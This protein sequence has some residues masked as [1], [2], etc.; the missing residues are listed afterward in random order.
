MK[1]GK[2]IAG[3]LSGAAIGA[4]AGML[5]AP[6]KGKDTRKQ[7]ADRSNEYMYDTKSKFN[8]LADNLSH[9]YD[10]VKSKM[11]GKSHKVSAKMDGD[12]KIIY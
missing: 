5:F 8:D 11:R 3:I 4:V 2:V 12:D 6:K 7:I 1:A 9:Q 10:S